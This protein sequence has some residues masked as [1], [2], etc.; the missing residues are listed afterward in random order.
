MI[1]RSSVGLLVAVA[2]CDGLLALQHV[3]DPNIVA[4]SAT[5]ITAGD[6]HSCWIRGDGMLL[7]WG[8]NDAG[9][10]GIRSDVD[11][12]DVIEQVGNA[13][14]TAISAEQNSTC[15]RPLP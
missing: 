8:G 1:G 3:P 11:E 15:R 2:A 13:S 5:T 9:Q 6:H 12:P 7:C 14:W 10:L 4:P